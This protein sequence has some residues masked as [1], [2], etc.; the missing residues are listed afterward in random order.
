VSKRLFVAI[1]IPET[2]QRLLDSLNP[3]LSGVRWAD[4]TQMHLT[5]GFF[6]HVLEEVAAHFGDKLRAIHFGSFFLPIAGL[7]AFPPKR[8]PKVVWVGVGSGHPHLFQLHKRV[9]EAALAVGI[10]A[11]LRPWHPHVTVA[12]CTDVSWQSVKKFLQQNADFDAGSIRVDAFHLYS[13][14]LTPAGAIHSREVTID[15]RNI[16]APRP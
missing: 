7:G 8:A 15:A 16:A 14:R 3:H 11:D 1:D 13:S 4:P 12:R 5:L 2:A 9:Q 10:E 6:G